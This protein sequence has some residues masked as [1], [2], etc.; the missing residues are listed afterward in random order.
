MIEKIG[1]LWYAGLNTKEIA[2]A[3]SN[4]ARKR[5]PE[6]SVFNILPAAKKAYKEKHEKP[7][8]RCGRTMMSRHAGNRICDR[9]KIND[10]SYG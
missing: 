6:S 9:C 4:A 1:E 3:L 8:L 7:C 2:R 10:G 5:M